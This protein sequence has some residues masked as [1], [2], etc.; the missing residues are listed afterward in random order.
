MFTFILIILIIVLLLKVTQNDPYIGLGM[1]LF[2]A[3]VV[4]IHIFSDIN[5]TKIE[6]ERKLLKTCKGRRLYY[7]SINVKNDLGFKKN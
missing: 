7:H 1:W 5:R 6:D 4:L 2:L 3:A